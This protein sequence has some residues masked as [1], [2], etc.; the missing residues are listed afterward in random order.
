MRR[1]AFLL[2]VNVYIVFENVLLNISLFAQAYLKY[3]VQ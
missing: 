1:I 2:A 3:E